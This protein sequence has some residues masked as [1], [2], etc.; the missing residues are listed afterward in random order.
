MHII[1]LYQSFSG[2]CT[3]VHQRQNS[4]P[5]AETCS[6]FLF[7][8]FYL[9]IYFFFFLHYLHHSTSEPQT[10]AMGVKYF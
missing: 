2:Y 10:A 3:P 4:D 6:L 9:F 1:A 5:V 7:I 8:Y